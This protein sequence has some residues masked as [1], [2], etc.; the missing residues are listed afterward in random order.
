[1]RPPTRRRGSSFDFPLDHPSTAA[2][3]DPEHM[4]GNGV[5]NSD[6]SEDGQ[7]GIGRR[8]AATTPAPPVLSRS[9]TAPLQPHMPALS[10]GPLLR[11]RPRWVHH[12]RSINFHALAPDEHLTAVTYLTPEGNWV[13]LPNTLISDRYPQ[14]F[15]PAQVADTTALIVD[16]AER[17]IRMLPTPR[18]CI[19]CTRAA[20]LVFGL[21]PLL[22]LTLM[23]VLVLEADVEGYFGVSMVLGRP[24]I[25][26]CR[27]RYGSAWP[28]LQYVALDVHQQDIPTAAAAAAGGGGQQEVVIGDDDGLMAG[29]GTGMMWEY[30]PFQ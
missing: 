3:P 13:T 30:S 2:T 27:A 9:N 18:G 20:D 10:A 26:W 25:Q 6:P 4:D 16:L 29:F 24:F 21:G 14:S 23:R 8:I 1:M 12:P 5:G 7:N 11:P 19:T 28:L 15:I 17:D 22:P